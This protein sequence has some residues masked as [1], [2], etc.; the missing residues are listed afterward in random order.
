MV[1]IANQKL[2]PSNVSKCMQRKNENKTHPFGANAYIW[3]S[4]IIMVKVT[5]LS[6]KAGDITYPRISSRM[7]AR[8]SSLHPYSTINTPRP[9][10]NHQDTLPGP[11]DSL[12][13]LPGNSGTM[14]H[15]EGP[16]CGTREPRDQLGVVCDSNGTEMGEPRLPSTGATWEYTPAIAMLAFNFIP[17]RIRCNR[18]SVKILMFWWKFYWNHRLQGR[19][20]LDHCPFPWDNR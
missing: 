14:W 16:V 17:E 19:S 18:N 10:I 11:M 12:G 13:Q 9:A 15:L 1:Q 2:R 7:R 3:A 4:P 20:Q 6:S 5:K 8:S